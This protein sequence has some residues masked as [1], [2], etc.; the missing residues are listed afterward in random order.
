MAEGWTTQ[1]AAAAGVAAAT[2]AAQLGL[3]Y[4]LGVVQWPDIATTDNSVWLG[5]LGWAT[6]IAASST[7]FGAVLASRVSARTGGPWRF[8]LAV[9]AA[10]G[11]L[12]AV[13]LI[14]LP[15]RAAVRVDTYTPETIAGGYAVIGVLLGLVLAYWAVVSRPVAANLTATAVWLWAMAVAA[16]VVELTMHRDSATY[17]TSWQFADVGEAARYGTI[18][19]PSSVLTLLA[20]LIVGV[21]GALPAARRGDLGVGAAASGAIGPLLVG[22]SF[23]VLAPQ[24]TGALGPLE[25]AYLIAPY[26]VL[27]GLAGS[28]TTVGLAQR[29]ANRSRTAAHNAA[30]SRATPATGVAAVPEPAPRRRV[31]STPP[32]SAQPTDPVP[33]PPP[34]DDR[35]PTT[36]TARTKPRLGR[37]NPGGQPPIAQP[38]T[39]K[40]PTTKGPT[41]K[42]PATQSPT[43]KSPTT[44]GPATKSPTAGELPP[45]SDP[46]ESTATE[47]PEPARDV[48]PKRGAFGWMR[49]SRESADTQPANPTSISPPPAAPAPT[50]RPP[51]APQPI[52]PRSTT[53]PRPVKPAATS[54]TQPPESANP[55]STVAPPPVSPTIAKIN[56]PR[57]GDSTPS[58]TS[59]KSTPPRAAPAK[60][61]SAKSPPPKQP[62]AANRPS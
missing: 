50:G 61:P 36:A 28:A 15:A 56:P 41:T 55:R 24:L 18:Y 5:S 49:R 21:I 53:E 42:S 59:S 17:L 57:S 1:V 16:I 6:W 51:T 13:A 37:T 12:L 7:V 19:W 32:T 54:P 31:R 43:T 35:Q 52:K 48:K 62:P 20:A 60:R 22:A 47:Q 2:G 27:T 44:K 3:G 25:S 39:T 10:V 23:F 11:A 40:G 45:A 34:P 4:G 30:R 14:A 29:S 9:S 38:S 58:E 33:A 8:A 26:A 46:W